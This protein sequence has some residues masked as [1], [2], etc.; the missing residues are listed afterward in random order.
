[1]NSDIR[2]SRGEKIVEFI[3][4]AHMYIGMWALGMWITYAHLGDR[5]EDARTAVSSIAALA[6]MLGIMT[7]IFT[8]WAAKFIRW[9]RR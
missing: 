8:K 1:M 5:L 2:K 4:S 9:V 7:M 6:I 3:L